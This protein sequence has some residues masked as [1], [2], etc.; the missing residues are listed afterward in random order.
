[1]YVAITDRKLA[2]IGDRGIHERVG[3][4]YWARLV[5]AVTAHFRAEHA[6]DGF[7]HAIAEVGAVLAE[8]FPRRP[9][10]VNELG[11]EVSI[12]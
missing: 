9:D 6:R 2:V 8:H 4:E 7:I 10:D 5:A 11:D 12:T 1:V 3:Q